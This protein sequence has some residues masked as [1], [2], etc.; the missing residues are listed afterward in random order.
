M[1]L[2]SE[3]YRKKRRKKWLKIIGIIFLLLIIAL[4]AYAYSIYKSLTD[5]VDSMH[6]PLDRNVRKTFRRHKLRQR[7][8]FSVLLWALTNAKATK[9]LGYDDSVNGQSEKG[10]HQNVEHSPRHANGNCRPGHRRQN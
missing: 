3:R 8:P 1:E 10:I 5:A 4:G 2:R 6:Q 9:A 7:D